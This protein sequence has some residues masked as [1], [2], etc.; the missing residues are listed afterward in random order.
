M[1]NIIIAGNWKMN[2]RISEA[3]ELAT[4]LK[5]KIGNVSDIKIVI[6]P[7]TIN[8]TTTLDAVKGSTI[9]VG[10]Q[11]ISDKESGA[12]T[13]E[14]AADMVAETGATYTLI[15]HSERREYYGETNQLVNAKIKRAYQHNLIPIVC[16]GETLAQRENNVTFSVIETQLKEGL[17]G[18][19]E[20]IINQNKTIVVAYEPVWA[21]G[22]GKVASKEQAQEV[23]AFIRGKLAEIFNA[24][25]AANITI[26]YGGS[27]KA[28]N[29]KELINQ[30][31]IDGA[32]VGGAS[33][34]A[35]SFADIVNFSRVTANV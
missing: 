30:P 33:L 35:D 34:N 2:T 24:D 20:E 17:S 6:C 18:L 31:D 5:E 14:T 29:I 7:P 27:V 22:T 12:Y 15:G 8:L 1:R 4:Q 26:Q 19:K 21:I 10:T 9:Q 11:N 3:Q 16:V 32:L 13:G 23:H 28:D 25:I